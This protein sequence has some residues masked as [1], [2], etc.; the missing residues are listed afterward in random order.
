M[1]KITQTW[2]KDWGYPHRAANILVFHGAQ[3]LTSQLGKAYKSWCKNFRVRGYNTVTWHVDA[4]KCGAFLW[5]S[6]LVT[7]CYSVKS[8]R[9]PP[10]RLD[11]TAAMRPCRNIIRTYNI[12]KS[13][14]QSISNLVPSTH[15]MQPN[16][17]GTVE[18]QP[19]YTWDGPSCGHT[20]KSW[21]IVPDVGIR[22]VQMDELMKLKGLH[23]SMY[24]NMNPSIL[25]SSI[26]QHVWACLGQCISPFLH[27][28]PSIPP[29]LP[30]LSPTTIQPQIASQ[31]SWKHPDLRKGRQFYK[32]SVHRLQSVVVSLGSKYAHLLGEG[33]GILA[34]HRSNYGVEG[35]VHL[36]VLWWEWPPLHWLELREGVSMNFMEAPTPGLVPNQELK[37][38]ELKEAVNFV[39]ELIEL[40]VLR[41]PP[42]ILQLLNNFP[43]FL[44]PK[45]GQPGQFRTIADG[46]AGGQN[47]V[48]IA[49][50]C[51]MT[52]PDHILPYLYPGGYSASLDLSK[53]FHM[54]LTHPKEHQYLGLLHPETL[55]EYIYA[56]LP[57]G[58]RNSPGAFGRFGA[59]F[60]RVVMDTSDLFQGNPVDNSLQQYFCHKISN[61]KYG[62]GRVLIGA[63]GLPAVLIWL[64]VD[65]LLI[66]ASTLSKLEAALNHIMHTTVRLGL[67]C[68]PSKTSPP[69]Q[70]VKYCGF[71]YDTTS[72][73]SLHIPSNKVSR[74]IA[75]TE[76]LISGIAI[77]HSRLVVSMVVGFLQSLVPATPGNIGA[78]F[79]RPV[80]K[81]LHSLLE[82]IT[83][84][85]KKSYI[86]LWI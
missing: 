37:G 5:S 47:E 20:A 35:P 7:F 27:K 16:Y 78:S 38:V 60:L 86:V 76:Y 3:F 53:Y 49:D 64:H 29:R 82:G 26:E 19:V 30:N 52:S 9:H 28:I 24:T 57:M 69:S 25:F 21:I 39:N 13:Q 48:C 58:T 42:S 62:E 65:D 4:V 61:P 6:Y 67:I 44:V 50:P 71:E 68:H 77:S 43:L 23:D 85:T 34:A 40:K 73:P 12:Y 10:L 80:Y 81:D 11:M 32:D 63:D 1:N 17:V 33:L 54:F 18:H 31:W 66:H 74:A 79:L 8:D 46:K 15:P 70:R 55:K 75:M 22:R 45:P 2:M 56:T 36:T 41:P 51:H 83:P 72:T 14:Y 59:A 84:G